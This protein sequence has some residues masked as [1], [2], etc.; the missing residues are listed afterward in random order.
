MPP[1]AQPLEFDDTANAVLPVL[2][3]S[4]DEEVGIWYLLYYYEI[5]YLKIIFQARAPCFQKDKHESRQH[6]DCSG[7]QPKRK[8]V[9][10]FPSGQI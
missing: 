8:V 9:S 6:G 3:S 4:T 10:S 2:Y 5:Y 1:T 7:G